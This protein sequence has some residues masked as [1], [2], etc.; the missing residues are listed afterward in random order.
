MAELR[1]SLNSTLD[2]IMVRFSFLQTRM[3]L[4]GHRPS[5]TNQTR[6]RVEVAELYGGGEIGFNYHVHEGS[7]LRVIISRVVGYRP[8]PYKVH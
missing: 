5:F 3:T 4:L 7:Y 8:E 1:N 2:P 6:V